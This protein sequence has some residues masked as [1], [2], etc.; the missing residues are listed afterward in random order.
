MRSDG[1]CR[2][3]SNNNINECKKTANVP[4]L[5]VLPGGGWDNL[6]NM[7]MGRVM[8]MNY[9]LCQTTEDGVYLLPDQV[10]TVPQKST[11][12]EINSEII[13][14]WLEQTSTTARSINLEVSFNPVLQGKFSVE[15]ERMKKHQVKENTCTSRTQVRNFIYSVKARPGFA[16][17]PIFISRVTDIANALENNETRLA[18]YLSE[19]LVLDYGTHVLTSV[20]AGA[21]LMKED[22]LRKSFVLKNKNNSL[23]LSAR[24]SFFITVDTGLQ[25][26]LWRFDTDAYEANIIYSLILSHGGVPFYP[27]ISLKTWQQSISNNL[28]AIDRSGLPLHFFLNKQTLPDLPDPTILKLASAVSQAIQRY[29]T[30]NTHPGCTDPGSSNYNY[31]AN[32]DDQ[33]CGGVTKNLSLGGVFQRCTPLTND[34]EALEMCKTL[35]QKNPQTGDLSCMQPYI[36]AHLRTEEREQG[37]SEFECRQVCHT[38]WLL[39]TCCKDACGEVYHM[40]RVRV[41][42][43]WCAGDNIIVPRTPGYLFG[44]LYG[45]KL[46]NPLTKSKGCPGE[47][48][49]F[50]LTSEGLKIC[51]SG[52]H[53][54]DARFAVPF[55]GLFSCE[56]GNPMAGGDSRCPAGFTQ[57]SAGVSDGCDLLF[58]T[59]SDAFSKEEPARIRLPPYTRRPLEVQNGTETVAVVSEDG[60]AWVRNAG[61]KYWKKASIDKAQDM[62]EEFTLSAAPLEKGVLRMTL[63]FLMSA[64]VMIP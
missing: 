55:G 54:T 11:K 37:Y 23:S 30:V 64:A 59:S 4:G 29:Y 41:E 58:C 50:T 8:N 25:G 9:S 57:H 36:Q 15:N 3:T 49:P 52:N 19:T 24:V 6:R 18:A 27:R 43:Y 12:V 14:S 26:S 21:I 16:L 20:D 44:G 7:D 42:T 62:V 34:P 60:E 53:E 61:M 28:V 45:P 31:Q 5:G 13:E 46:V 40:H 35:T 51:L 48:V 2:A 32:V 38:C 39:F 22:Y 1:Y 10:F 56:A 17:D 63:A 47:F 33:S